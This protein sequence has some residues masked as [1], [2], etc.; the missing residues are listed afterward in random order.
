VRQHI[1]R[2]GQSQAGYTLV[3]VVVSAAIGAI[4][5]AGLSSVIY[6]STN[7]AKTAVSRIEASGQIRNF[8]LRA[9]DDFAL[10]SIPLIPAGCGGTQA[11]PCT[12]QSIKLTGKQVANLGVPAPS[13]YYYAATYT[14]EGTAAACGAP[15][16]PCF[17]DRTVDPNTRHVATGVSAFSWYLDGTA[18]D[19]TVVV[20]LTV[21]VGTYSDSQTFRFRP[22]VNP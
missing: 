13:P 5:L 15:P 6:T 9:Y 4:L 12:T 18:L 2:Y 22:Q 17:L 8:E 16:P 10:S 3:E 21:T 7:A 19:R 1:S 11:S 14:W 20:S